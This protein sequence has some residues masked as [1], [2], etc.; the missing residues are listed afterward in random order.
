MMN[1][2]PLKSPSLCKMFHLYRLDRVAP[3]AGKI[4]KAS[5]FKKNAD[6]SQKASV[7]FWIG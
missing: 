4:I 5:P 1:H 7:S 6:K 3:A 2:H